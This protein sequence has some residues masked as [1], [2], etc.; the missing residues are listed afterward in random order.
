MEEEEQEINDDLSV[1]KQVWTEPNSPIAGRFI[2]IDSEE[3][4]IHFATRKELE[5]AHLI[6]REAAKAL[7][8]TLSTEPYKISMSLS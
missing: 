7:E 6:H 5:I 1:L 8:K 4:E 3:K 2:F